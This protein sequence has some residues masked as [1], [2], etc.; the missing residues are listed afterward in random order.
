LSKAQLVAINNQIVI[1]WQATLAKQA[2]P[3]VRD[4]E[5]T[6]LR[7]LAA[8][9]QEFAKYGLGGARV[10][11]IATRAKSNK[12]MLYH[13]FG[14]KD[15]LFAITVENAYA[16]F[17]EKEAA[18]QLDS[19]EPV[20]AMR[21]LVS[22]IWDY[23]IAH[24]EFITLVNSENLH[25]AKHLKASKRNTDMSR[26]FVARMQA[27][28]SRGEAC[29]VFRHGLDPVQVNISIAAI[30]YY[31]LTNQFTGSIVFERDLM[32]KPALAARLSFNTAT[33]LRMVCTAEEIA[34]LEKSGSLM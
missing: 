17:R 20:A 29:G 3:Q 28:L 13:Y 8:A 12:R 11:R 15:D 4:P 9:T 32:T 16:E 6:K 34:R 1:C 23:F 21:R 31:Y 33:T 10:D 22:F 7:I 19:L 24:P 27:L 14:N 5:A 25:K 30:A 26:K 2:K 18:L